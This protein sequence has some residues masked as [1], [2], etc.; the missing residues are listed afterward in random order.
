M[1]ATATPEMTLSEKVGCG[2]LWRLSRAGLCLHRATR[3][4]YLAWSGAV[5]AR[6]IPTYTTRQELDALYRLAHGLPAGARVLEI[7]SY[8]GASTYALAA[9]LAARGGTIWCVDTWENQTMPEGPRDTLPGFLENTAR[10]RA[11]IRPVRKRSDELQAE[12]AQTPLDLI[13]IDG[14]HSYEAVRRDIERVQAWVAPEGVIAFHDAT[15]FPGVGRA[16]GELLATTEWAIAGQVESLVWICRAA[17]VGPP[18]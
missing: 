5:P 7:G 3:E 6:P 13:F 2:L 10:F 14:D 11:M 15:S 4:R 17:W 1:S 8:L 12:D 18:G 16:V 9:G